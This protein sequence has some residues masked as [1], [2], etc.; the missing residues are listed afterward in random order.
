MGTCGKMQGRSLG[1]T[2]PVFNGNGEGLQ[3]PT[4]TAVCKERIEAQSR[5]RCADNRNAILALTR[6][7]ESPTCNGKAP[8]KR[9]DRLPFPHI[10]CVPLNKRSITIKNNF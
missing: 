9:H 3:P 6:G 1:K 2:V 10:V 4:Q 7:H 5:G 8:R